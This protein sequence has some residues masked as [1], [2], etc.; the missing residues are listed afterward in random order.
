MKENNE[1]VE[2]IIYNSQTDYFD[3]CKFVMKLYFAQNEK[4]DNMS[5]HIRGTTDENTINGMVRFSMGCETLMSRNNVTVNYTISDN[6]DIN[7]AYDNANIICVWKKVGSEH[8]TSYNVSELRYLSLKSDN[9]E[10]L[11]KFIF[12]SVSK[13]DSNKPHVLRYVP[14]QGAWAVQGV[15]DERDFDTLILDEN[16]KI[17]ELVTDLEAFLDPNDGKK[18]AIKYGQPY[19]KTY[20]FYGPPGTGKTS[21][22]KTLARKFDLDIMIFSFQGKMTD[23]DLANALRTIKNTSILL[24]EDIDCAFQKRDDISYQGITHSGLYNLLDGVSST[25]GLVT[26]ITT[27]YIEKLDNALIRPG[28]IDMMIPFDKFTRK[29]VEKIFDIYEKTYS[30]ETYDYIHNECKRSSIP[31]AGLSSFLFRNRKNN[32]SDDEIKNRFSE[33]IKEYTPFVRVTKNI[34]PNSNMFM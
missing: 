29:Q 21:L 27:N 16:S 10:I 2:Y 30:P 3:I 33:Y 23:D 1:M 7:I 28:R 4:C 12:E 9:N 31:P 5:F 8:G 17:N 25:N 24:L 11:K 34:T 19:V 20:M 18:A 32:L 22:V 13:R 26:I 14:R 6:I 15:V